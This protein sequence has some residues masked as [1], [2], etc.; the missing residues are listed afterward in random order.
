MLLR[1]QGRTGNANALGTVEGILAGLVAGA[2][3]SSLPYS[4]PRS[5]LLCPLIY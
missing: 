4:L 2:S 1:R 3:S 5:N